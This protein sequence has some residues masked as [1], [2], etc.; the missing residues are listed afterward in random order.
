[1]NVYEKKVRYFYSDIWEAKKLENL[2]SVLHEKFD[3]RGSLGYEKHTRRG[4]EDYVR[5]I[6]AAL[7]D[8]RCRIEELV[9]QSNKVFAKMAFSGIH[10]AEFLGYEATHERV[11]WEGAALFTFTE[12]KISDLWV[13]GDIKKLEQQLAGPQKIT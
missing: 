5:F 13:L 12:E 8:Y 9:I 10:D 6:H 4:F 11:S 1:M 3:F 2:S 7:S